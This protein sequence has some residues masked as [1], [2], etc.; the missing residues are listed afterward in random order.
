MNQNSE[1][2]SFYKLNE[3][4]AMKIAASQI[5]PIENNTIENI[6][7]HL[8]MIELAAKQKVEL[9]VFPE[10]SLTGYERELAEQ[11]SFS[12]NDSRLKVFE[13]KAI[14][15]RMVI[16]VGA[17]IKINSKLHIGSFVFF[18]GG[19]SLIYTKQ[20]LHDGEEEYFTP[21]FNYNPL[22]EFKNEKIS[23]AICADIANSKHPA[24]ASEKNTTL[25]LASFFYS[26]HGVTEGYK[27]LSSYAKEYSMNVLMANFTGSSYGI[28]AA[29]QS[30]FWNKDGE[31]I[32]QLNEVEENLLII[33]I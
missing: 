12:E 20:F 25:Y 4:N 33:E 30:A 28:K 15:H 19:T 7:N 14:I 3:I 27:T 2:I 6:N 1:L 22:I 10:M 13:D 23:I 5:K 29:G 8:R 32:E 24:N 11:L 31:L 26:P 21:N 18:P 17:P 16:I 9:I